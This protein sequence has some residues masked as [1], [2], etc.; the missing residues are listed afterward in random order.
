MNLGSDSIRLLGSISILSPDFQPITESV[1]YHISLEHATIK[2][3]P[4]ISSEGTDLPGG[5]SG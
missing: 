5:N 1:T 4:F 2:V 3:I